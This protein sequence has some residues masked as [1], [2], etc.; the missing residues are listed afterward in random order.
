MK[1]KSRVL[2]I[3]A[4]R[5]LL[6]WCM[7]GYHLLWNSVWWGWLSIDLAQPVWQLI[8]MTIAAGFLFLVGV[9]LQVRYFR[10]QN[11][12]EYRRGVLR[13][14]IVIAA[15]ALLITIV[16][17]FVTPILMVRFGVLHLIATVVLLIW[18]IVLLPT[19][20][21]ITTF[22]VVAMVSGGRLMLGPV[23]VCQESCSQLPIVVEWLFSSSGLTQPLQ[24]SLDYYP[25]LPWISFPLIGVVCSK[26]L[27]RHSIKKPSINFLERVLVFSGQHALE[28]YLIHQ[29]I[30]WLIYSLFNIFFRTFD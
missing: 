8:R 23:S 7:V 1:P 24:G 3:D 29:P 25:V 11:L 14:G 17:R 10:A 2:W 18:P 9:S 26:W 12:A 30:I 16:T 13:H 5:G 27:L 19:V 4:L 20:A 15:A 21:Q 6:V 28:I 22:A